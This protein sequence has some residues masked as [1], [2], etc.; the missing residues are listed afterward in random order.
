MG[1]SSYTVNLNN[2]PQP[3]LWKHFRNVRL[4]ATKYWIN[5]LKCPRVGVNDRRHYVVEAT[6]PD[7]MAYILPSHTIYVADQKMLFFKLPYPYKYFPLLVGT[8]HL[9]KLTHFIQNVV[10]RI[11]YRIIMMAF[12]LLYYFK[13]GSNRPSVRAICG[14]GLLSNP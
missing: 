1:S 2:C 13:L 4:F 10:Y 8:W 14:V 12:R 9:L 3:H 7:V 11:V 6:R 5:L